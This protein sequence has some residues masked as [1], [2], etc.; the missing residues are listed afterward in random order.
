MY[1]IVKIN[2]DKQLFLAS[3]KLHTSWMQTGE[4]DCLHVDGIR[5]LAGMVGVVEWA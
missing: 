4:R 1:D 3:P 2:Y 5:C